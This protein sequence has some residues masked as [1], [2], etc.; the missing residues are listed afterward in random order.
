MFSYRIVSRVA[1]VVLA[2]TRLKSYSVYMQH[3]K[4][5]DSKNRTSLFLV[6]E[7][8]FEPSTFRL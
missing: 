7:E 4:K 5:R 2:P 6:A 1:G 8:G 3:K